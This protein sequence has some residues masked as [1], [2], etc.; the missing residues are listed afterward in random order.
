[1]LK[2]QD[3]GLDYLSQSAERL[4][5]MSLNISEELEQQNKMLDSMETDLDAAGED[6]D[7]VTR[8]TQEFIKKAGG[9]GNFIVIVVLSLVAL[10][11][12]F[13]V[14]YT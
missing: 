1:M 5:Q 6:L 12:F 10:V 3:E 13:L 9:T 8:K 11:L 7:M 14:L 2:K 4:G